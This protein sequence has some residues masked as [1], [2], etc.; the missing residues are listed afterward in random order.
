MI[1]GKS[2]CFTPVIPPPGPV[3]RVSTAVI[4][5]AELA[6]IIHI[7]SHADID[8]SYGALGA[9]VTQHALAVDGPIREYYL[10]DPSQTR[11]ESMWRT[12]IGWRHS[13]SGPGHNLKCRS[14]D[15]GGA[16][17]PVERATLLPV[18]L[19]TRPELRQGTRPTGLRQRPRDGHCHEIIDLPYGRVQQQISP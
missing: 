17:G 8:Q 9:Y 4:P 16:L 15:P 7:G 2:H 5:S 18:F 12:E 10:V 19:K 14:A 1:G 6:V 11:D 3:G 13:K